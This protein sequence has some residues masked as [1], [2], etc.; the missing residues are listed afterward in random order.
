MAATM[1]VT[2]ANNVAAASDRQSS[3]EPAPPM[4]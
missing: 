2:P 1:D 3:N 4:V